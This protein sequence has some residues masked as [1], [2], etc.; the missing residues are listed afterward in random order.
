MVQSVIVIHDTRLLLIQGSKLESSS[1]RDTVG[2]LQDLFM[3]VH[4]NGFET[5]VPTI[6]PDVQRFQ[7]LI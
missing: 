7:Y 5:I 3:N 1:S 4:R 2:W 6:A